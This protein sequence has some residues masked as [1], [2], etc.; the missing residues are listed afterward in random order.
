MVTTVESRPHTEAV[1]AVLA[2]LGRPVG[3]CTRPQGNP[4]FIVVYPG[5]GGSRN[6][7]IADPD[8]DAVLYFRIICVGWDRAG[9]EWMADRVAEVMPTLSVPGRRAHR[10]TL[11]SDSGVSRDDDVTPPLYAATPLWRLWTSPA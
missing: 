2:T 11:E 5:Q 6:G 7:T 3:D 10:I 1:L 8:A 4:P 9:A